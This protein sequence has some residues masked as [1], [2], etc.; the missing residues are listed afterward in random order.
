[1]RPATSSTPDDKER[2][3]V[4]DRDAEAP[5]ADRLDLDGVAVNE[6]CVA[7]EFQ[8]GHL[9]VPLLV[10][11]L[12]NK[13]RN[14]APGKDAPFRFFSQISGPRGTSDTASAP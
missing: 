12:S 1:L 11:L 8:E 9:R 7:A 14:G 2:L 6:V 13:H 5:V 3:T 10:H 4:I